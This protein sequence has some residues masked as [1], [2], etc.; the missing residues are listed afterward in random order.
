MAKVETDAV[1][2]TELADALFDEDKEKAAKVI[3]KIRSTAPT[4]VAVPTV[5][6]SYIDQSVET[7]LS[8]RETEAAVDRFSNEYPQL[9]NISGLRSEV[10]ARTI[11]EQK[12]DPNA[13]TWDIIDRSA[14]HVLESTAKALG[15]KMVEDT[16]P[17]AAVSKQVTEKGLRGNVRLERLWSAR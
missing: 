12:N 9:D 7:A 11:V 3:G 17:A 10:N 6:P 16:S 4:P 15:F 8:K 1:L 2:A 13:S 5:D 14:K